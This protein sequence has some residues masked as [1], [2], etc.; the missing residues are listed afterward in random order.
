[1]RAIFILPS[2]FGGRLK[3]G[4]LGEHPYYCKYLDSAKEITSWRDTRAK[5][6]AR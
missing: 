6:I 5:I 3:Y 2:V 4:S 1:M